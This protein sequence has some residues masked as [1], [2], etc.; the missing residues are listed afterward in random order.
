MRV[1]AVLR[2][3][4]AHASGSAN[5]TGAPVAVPAAW[6][7]PDGH[8]AGIVCLRLRVP[9]HACRVF[10]AVERSPGELTAIARQ[11]SGSASRIV[12]CGFV[13]WEMGSRAEDAEISQVLQITSETGATTKGPN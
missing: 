11:G 1:T 3:V 8:G 5:D 9:A 7:V 4:R 12:Y 6:K 13:R 2:E 10:G